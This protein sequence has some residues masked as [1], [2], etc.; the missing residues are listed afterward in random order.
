MAP[1]GILSV[2]ALLI[3]KYDGKGQK[4]PDRRATSPWVNAILAVLFITE[5][6]WRWP[7]RELERKIAEDFNTALVN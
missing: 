6:S 1:T 2:V 5:P 4:G 7:L 3:N